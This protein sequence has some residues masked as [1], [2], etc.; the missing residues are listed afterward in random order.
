MAKVVLEITADTSALGEVGT[1]MNKISVSAK[2]AGADQSKAFKDASEAATKLNTT[3]SDATPTVVLTKQKSALQQLKQEI[4]DYEN[5][6]I[7]AGEGTAEFAKNIA[8]AGK[9]KADLKDLKEAIGALDPDRVAKGFLGLARSIAGGFTLAQSAIALTGEQNKD[10]EKTLLKVQAAQ[11]VLA[12]LQELANTKDELAK[13]KIIGLQFIQLANTK[14]QTAAESENVIV[15]GLAIAAQTAL[16]AVTALGS[17]GVLLLVG[18]IATLVAGLSRWTSGAESTA[19]AEKRLNDEL[20]RSNK[21]TSAIIDA[22][23]TYIAL[24]KAQGATDAQLEKERVATF[25]LQQSQFDEEIKNNN[26]LIEKL[27]ERNNEEHIGNTETQ[28]NLKKIGDL[29][30]SNTLL[31]IKTISNEQKFTAQ[32]INLA[33]DAYTKLADIAGKK[34]ALQKAQSDKDFKEFKEKQKLLNDSLETIP[35]IPIFSNIVKSGEEAVKSALKVDEAIQKVIS[36]NTAEQINPFALLLSNLSDFSEKY[37]AFTDQIKQG[38]DLISQLQSADTENKI[39]NIDNETQL[40]L[41]AVDSEIEKRKDAKLSFE[42]LEKEKQQIQIDADAQVKKLQ[43]E[44]FER[45]KRYQKANAIINGA[46][47]ILKTYAEYGF[48]PVGLAAAILDAAITSLQIA[49]IDKQEFYKGGYTGDGGKYQ[50]AGTVHRG[51]FVTT[52]E[53]TEKHR[54]LLEAI[55]TGDYSMLGSSDLAPILNGTG[56]VLKDDVPIRINQA[57]DDARRSQTSAESK[58]L[59]AIDRK[60]EDF[61]KFYKGKPDEVIESDGTKIIRV[62]NTVRRIR[63]L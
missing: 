31:R 16:N 51:E 47:S 53:K 14:L 39:K 52:K 37:T 35:S 10:L 34:E 18:G 50:E 36:N 7:K 59:T 5:A 63:K 4:K 23:E 27:K 62:G 6:A 30:A 29:Q 2:K 54:N 12:G 58:V 11:G 38:I 8:L 20:E 19:D 56:V 45:N 24:R 33:N 49:V 25:K 15:K 26:E 46:Q 40:R 42:D 41:D 3:L 55:H 60:M 44:Q 1:E 32:E 61:F 21:L 22:N 9:K 57:H 13:V 17:G 48:T 43:R 28:E